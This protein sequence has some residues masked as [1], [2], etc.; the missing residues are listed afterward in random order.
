MLHR[1]GAG[2]ILGCATASIVLLH[3][4]YPAMKRL[5]ARP[6]PM[7]VENCFPHALSPLDRYSF[8]SGHVMTL[9]AALVPIL[10]ASPTTW[11]LALFAWISM[12]WARLAVGHHYA[13]DIV[14]GTML[15]AAV[16]A[17]LVYCI[18]P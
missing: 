18:A 1:Q 15:G 12:A 9:T 5:T 17:G 13:S 10:N 3:A 7:D 6:R 16:S 4:V 11:P 8:P 14:A 2:L